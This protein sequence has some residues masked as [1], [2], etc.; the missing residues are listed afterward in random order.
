M[1]TTSLASNSSSRLIAAALA[2]AEDLLPP[3]FAGTKA[4][5][6]SA[7][8]AELLASLEADEDT[9]VGALIAP[10]VLS[11][12]LSHEVASANFGQPA[13]RFAVALG[14]LG[15]FRLTDRWT[16][17]RKLSAGQAEVLRK[18]LLA[19]ITDPRLVLVRL[20]EQLQDLREARE[21]SQDAQ[22]RL[23]RETR[24]VYAPLAS[25]LGI[26]QLKWELED[27]AFRYLEPDDYI[28]IA[29]KLNERRADRERYIA[30]IIEELAGMLTEVGINAEITGRPKHIYSIW[31]KMQ[32]KHL[33][34]EQVFDVRAVRVLTDSVADCY[35]ALGLVHGRWPY[36]PGEF[37]DYIAT[38]KGND[39]RSLHTAVIGP[40]KV[41]VE[42]QI[43]THEMH[44]HAELGVAAH[45]R[46]KE[47]AGKDAAYDRKIQWLRE[48]LTPATDGEA[49]HD[50][51][52]RVRADLFEDRVYVLTPKGDVVDLPSGATPLDYAYQ[53]HTELGHRCR[54]A[55]VNSK[56]VTL[57]YKLSNGEVVEIIAGKQPQPSRDW[58][59]DQ[60]GYLASP[61]SRAKVRAWFKRQD[62]GRNRQEGR[63]LFE[64][65]I[66]RLGLQNAVAMPELLTELGLPGADALHLALG[67]GDLTVAQVSGAIHRRIK[68]NAPLPAV[69]RTPAARRRKPS[70]GLEIEGVGDLASTFA[71]CCNPVPPE[72]IAGYITVGRGV[73]IHR[74]GCPSLERM[75]RRQPERVLSVSWGS[76]GERGFEVDIVIHA[77]DRHGL[78]RDVGTVLT[79]EKI[80]I[81][82]MTT[83]THAA[84]N[85]ADI[86]VTV[87]IRGLE[88]LSHLLT[89]LKSIRNVVSARRQ[90]GS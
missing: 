22:Q 41:P 6:R 74:E 25:R 8:V 3:E 2:T 33:S 69:T 51:L 49:D 79:E 67:A 78:V 89:R 87:T 82:R 50:F 83:E 57:D 45:W 19:V 24:E 31:K 34:F 62:E 68:V 85:T 61:R 5:G 1:K 38:P 86:H 52:D 16:P 73:T 21:L 9:V 58:L 55:R 88:E 35:A 72:A 63:E 26:W 11:G 12:T 65:E 48:L 81:I 10:L 53:V 44:E 46:Y 43:R 60:Q 28:L 14:S 70:A 40:G 90:T 54:G 29:R 39:Y 32:R 4:L 20:A 27:L 37:D 47:G 56:M 17:E 13:A 75:R 15:S 76:A 42:V 66:A 30:S 64:R 71:R 18:M 7:R 59:I 80:N 36:I 23:A 84:T 77:Y